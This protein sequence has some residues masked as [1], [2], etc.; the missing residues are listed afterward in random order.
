MRHTSTYNLLIFL[1]TLGIK[2]REMEYGLHRGYLLTF[3]QIYY[4]HALE[5]IYITQVGT[6]HKID[7]TAI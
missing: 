6:G 5:K 3:N 1:A 7:T 2:M 4:S